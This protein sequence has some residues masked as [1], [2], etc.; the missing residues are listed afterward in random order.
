M[1]NYLVN[2]HLRLGEY[3]KRTH[4][5]VAANDKKEAGVNALVAECHNTPD[6]SE[7]P[8]KNSVWDGCEFIYSV[9]SVQPVSDSDMKV[10]TNLGLR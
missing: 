6:F 3:E 2:L 8:E 4:V 5:V 10:L 7:F 9:W 1:K